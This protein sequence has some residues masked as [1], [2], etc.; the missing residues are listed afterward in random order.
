MHVDKTSAC[1]AYKTESS[2]TLAGA[3]DENLTFP[4]RIILKTKGRTD[5][6]RRKLCGC[7]NHDREVAVNQRIMLRLST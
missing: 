6:Y 3:L 4:I 2:S 1:A 5:G 7:V